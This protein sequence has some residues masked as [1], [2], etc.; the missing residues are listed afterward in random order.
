MSR[1][2]G[3]LPDNDRLFNLE[4]FHLTLKRNQRAEQTFP[5][6]DGRSSGG[7]LRPMLKRSLVLKTFTFVLTLSDVLQTLLDEDICY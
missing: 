5:F 1:P 7:A 3:A 4:V 6:C 2:F